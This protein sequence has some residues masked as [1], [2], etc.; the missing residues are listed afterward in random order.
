MIL[1]IALLDKPSKFSRKRFIDAKITA[2]NII[3]GYEPYRS[4]TS[5]PELEYIFARA[6]AS[7]IQEAITAAERRGGHYSPH[8]I[9]LE[10]EDGV[11]DAIR[12]GDAV[13]ELKPGQVVGQ[14]GINR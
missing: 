4:S 7:E 8:I 9:K 5:G 6:Q 13:Y 14:N 12:I 1:E 11:E 3:L 10:T 2:N